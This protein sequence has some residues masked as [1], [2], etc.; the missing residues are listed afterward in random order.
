ML[1]LDVVEADLTISLLNREEESKRV[2]VLHVLEGDLWIS[3][4]YM[5]KR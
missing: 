2:I 5:L 4:G 3:L 1:A